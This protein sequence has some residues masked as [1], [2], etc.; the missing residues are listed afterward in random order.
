[1]PNYLRILLSDH[2]SR[3]QSSLLEGAVRWE[4][5][6]GGRWSCWGGW[7]KVPHKLRLKDWTVHAARSSD[8]PMIKLQVSG[9]VSLVWDS[10]FVVKDDW[11]TF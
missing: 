4:C 10:R 9:A 5:G 1:M 2:Y 8:A 11:R 6:G 3:M 7:R